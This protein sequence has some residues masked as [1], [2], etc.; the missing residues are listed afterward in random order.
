MIDCSDNPTAASGLASK[1]GGQRPVG[2]IESMSQSPPDPSPDSLAASVRES[3]EHLQETAVAGAARVA[4][5]AVAWILL[6]TAGWWVI[7]G[8]ERLTVS[9]VGAILVVTV[10]IIAGLY[11][12]RALV[13]SLRSDR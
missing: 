6:G 4:L 9:A 8:P 2:V 12:V 10:A 7:V 11:L 13:V 1:S 5:W 3:I